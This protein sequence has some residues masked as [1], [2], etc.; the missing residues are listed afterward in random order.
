MDHIIHQY[1]YVDLW[2]PVW[3]NWFAGLVAAPVAFF[4]GK[5]FEKRAIGRHQE[6]MDKLEAIHASVKE[7][8]HGHK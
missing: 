1:V 2:Q 5:T 8:N 3:P 4:W 7:Q 6:H